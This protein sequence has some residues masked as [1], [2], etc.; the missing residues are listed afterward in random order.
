MALS[1]SEKIKVNQEITSVKD[2]KRNLL[3]LLV[4]SSSLYLIKTQF[5]DPV[6]GRSCTHI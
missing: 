3:T 6:G 2:S 1:K 4:Y 5:S